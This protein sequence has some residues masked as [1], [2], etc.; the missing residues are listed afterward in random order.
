MSYWTS[1]T[2]SLKTRATDGTE[3]DS[4]QRAELSIFPVTFRV[5]EIVTIR[6]GINATEAWS[7][8]L[9]SD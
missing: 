1:S 7:S 4:R 6:A 3:F 5:I 8:L 9:A 2:R